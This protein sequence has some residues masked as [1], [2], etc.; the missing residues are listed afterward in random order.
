MKTLFFAT[1]SGCMLLALSGTARADAEADILSLIGILDSGMCT[2]EDGDMDPSNGCDSE[3][4]GWFGESTDDF[5]IKGKKRKDRGCDPEPLYPAEASECNYTNSKAEWRH[6]A[7]RAAL[8]STY[9]D[10][11]KDNFDSSNRYACYFVGQVESMLTEQKID[12]N[13]RDALVPPAEL[14]ARDIGTDCL[15]LDP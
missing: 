13:G 9:R 4:D 14:I 5:K 6:D 8:E 15:D 12:A 1:L 3:F 7:L 2:Y 10:F 11:V